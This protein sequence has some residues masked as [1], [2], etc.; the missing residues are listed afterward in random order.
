MFVSFNSWGLLFFI[1]VQEKDEKIRSF[2]ESLKS[3]LKQESES[4]KTIEVCVW[5]FFYFIECKLIIDVT[6]W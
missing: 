1:R 3:A 2:E 4:V 5:S 6:A